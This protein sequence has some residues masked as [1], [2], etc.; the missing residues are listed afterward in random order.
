M[1]DHNMTGRQVRRNQLDHP[2]QGIVIGDKYLQVVTGLRQLGGRADEVRYRSRSAIPN[3]NGQSLATQMLGNA[4]ANNTEPNQT[5]VLT[6]GSRHLN[7]VKVTLQPAFK[8]AIAQFQL[9]TFDWEP[10][11]NGSANWPRRRTSS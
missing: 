1:C 9:T 2:H 3:K 7:A 8:L 6:K 4:P 11:W 5:N 10:S